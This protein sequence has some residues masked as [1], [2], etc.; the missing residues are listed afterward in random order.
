MTSEKVIKLE[1]VCVFGGGGGGGTVEPLNKGH[2]GTIHFV[3][4]NE[5]VLLRRL[6][7]Y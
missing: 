6:I 4:N 2:F 7:M 3:L 1:C 5:V